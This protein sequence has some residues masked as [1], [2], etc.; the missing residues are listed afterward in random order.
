MKIHQGERRTQCKRTEEPH[1]YLATA[2]FG[3]FC[4]GR[5]CICEIKI[6]T[7]PGVRFWYDFIFN[8]Y[9]TQAMYGLMCK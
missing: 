2:I 9:L 7:V 1:S 5:E 6:Y 4:E 3:T 8:Y